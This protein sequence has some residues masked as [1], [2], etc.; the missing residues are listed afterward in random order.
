MPLRIKGVLGGTAVSRAL[1]V[2]LQTSRA[3]DYLHEGERRG[4][5]GVARLKPRCVTGKVNLR[6]DPGEVGQEQN[7][8]GM[9]SSCR[10]RRGQRRTTVAAHFAGVTKLSSLVR[11][12][13]QTPQ[14]TGMRRLG[15]EGFQQRLKDA[16]HGD[17]YQQ[18]GGQAMHRESSISRGLRNL[19]TGWTRV[20][21]RHRGRRARRSVARP[22]GRGPLPMVCCVPQRPRLPELSLQFPLC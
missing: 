21:G 9:D 4:A 20:S 7:R 19:Q 1:P 8:V 6:I 2:Q 17:K 3:A 16:E 11:P 10:M 12:R 13:M 15:R 18:P 5:G 22:D 14:T